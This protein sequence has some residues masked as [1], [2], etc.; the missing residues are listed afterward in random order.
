M[1]ITL[2]TNY[3][4]RFLLCKLKENGLNICTKDDKIRRIILFYGALVHYES[5]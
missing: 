4:V 5:R 2:R 3:F 1:S